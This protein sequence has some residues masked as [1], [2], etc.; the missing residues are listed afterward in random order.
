MPRTLQSLRTRAGALLYDWPRLE[1]TLRGLGR[2]RNLRTPWIGMRNRNERLTIDGR[3]ARC[4]WIFTSDLHIARVFPSAGA[5]LM[6]RALRDWPI[7]FR[8]TRE[9]SSSPDVSF[10][11]GH[12]GLDRLPHLLATLRSVTGQQNASVECIVVEQS[13]APE[14]AASMPS[15]VRHLHTPLPALDSPYNRSWAFNVGARLARGRVLI[16]HDND[17]LSPAR[18]A[19]EAVERTRE[20]WCFLEL[21]R[22][23]FY[24]DETATR[25]LFATDA[26]PDRAPENVLQN[27]QGGSIAVTR[28]AFFDIGGFDESFVGWGGEDNEFWERAE[29]TKTVNAFGYLPFVHLWHAPQAGRQS[30]EA[31]AVRR[32]HELKDVPAEERIRRLRQRDWGSPLRPSGGE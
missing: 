13:A 21:K 2:Y 7:E 31:P 16:L 32:Y 11:I 18:Y 20:G 22:F 26:I 1:M 3:G 12:R 6:R 23:L 8:E 9:P 25:E 17:M 27:A 5:R 30:A 19:A 4:E 29:T 15:W 24:F 10:I 28:D 14:I